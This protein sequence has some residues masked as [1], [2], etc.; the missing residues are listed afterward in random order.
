M[1]PPDVYPE[2]AL[3]WPAPQYLPSVKSP[4]SVAL[5]SAAKENLSIILEFA[6]GL[7][8]EAYPLTV[9]PNTQ[10]GAAS[11]AAAAPAVSHLPLLNFIL[12]VDVINAIFSLVKLASGKAPSLSYDLINDPSTCLARVNSLPRSAALVLELAVAIFR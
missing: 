12:P 4:T 9:P 2:V 1:R 10:L 11:A 8:P 5:P 7:P 6:T 3:D